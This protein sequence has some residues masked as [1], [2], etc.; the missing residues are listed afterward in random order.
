MYSVGSVG[1]KRLTHREGLYLAMDA[2]PLSQPE[3]ELREET[4][5]LVQ[6]LVVSE[7]ADEGRADTPPSSEMARLFEIA[8]DRLRFV[9]EKH[10]RSERENHTLQPTALV[11]EAFLRLVDQDQ[12]DLNGHSHFLAIASRAMR[13]VLVDHARRHQAAKRGGDQRRVTLDSRIAGDAPAD[14]LDVL[15]VDE[16]LRDLTRWNERAGKVAELR[17]FGGMTI[18][19]VARTIGRSER[20]VAGEWALAKVWLSRRFCGGE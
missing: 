1:R 11:N 7:S 17:I 9:A 5:R 3:K 4:T 20:T 19:A 18:A 13:Q 6:T 8:Y 16:A 14:P 15:A 2:N 12:I 10:L